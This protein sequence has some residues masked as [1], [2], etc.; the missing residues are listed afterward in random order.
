MALW[1]F[2]VEGEWEE[3]E[4]GFVGMDVLFGF[5]FESCGGWRGCLG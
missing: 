4:R 3:C 2:G 1:C 5:G